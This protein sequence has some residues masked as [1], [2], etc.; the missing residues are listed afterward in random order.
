MVD[1]RHRGRGR[2][3][4]ALGV[5]PLPVTVLTGFLGAGKTTLLG[6]LLVEPHGQRVGVILNE[7]GIA[8]IDRLGGPVQTSYV[9]LTNGCVCCVDQPDLLAAVD[10][11]VGRGDLDRLVLETT[12]LADPLPLTWTLSR[13]ELAAVGRLAGVVRV[14]DAANWSRTQVAEC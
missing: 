14:V 4:Y 9:E 8:G 6:R 10:G 11:L 13:P 2:P 5:P 3:C 12:G 7:I 1:R